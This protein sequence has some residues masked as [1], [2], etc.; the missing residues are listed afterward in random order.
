MF[1]LHPFCAVFL[2]GCSCGVVFCLKIYIYFLM[3]CNLVSP[4][5]ANGD[6]G[7]GLEISSIISSASLVADY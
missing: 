2:W 4:M 3:A 1:D 7:A 6:V 5:D